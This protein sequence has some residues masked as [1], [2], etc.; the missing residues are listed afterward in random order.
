MNILERQYPEVAELIAGLSSEQAKQVSTSVAEYVINKNGVDNPE[1]LS[2][3]QIPSSADSKTLS[4][5]SEKTEESYLQAQARGK[6]DEY[7]QEFA[8]ARAI[9]ALMYAI[10]NGSQE[11]TAQSIYEATAANNGNAEEVLGVMR[12]SLTQQPHF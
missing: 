11:N 3:L 8:K 1:V 7:L 10:S 5:L 9:D 12:N 4:S 2:A 6:I